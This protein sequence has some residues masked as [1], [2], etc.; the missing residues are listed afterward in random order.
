MERRASITSLSSAVTAKVSASS[1]GTK[2][3]PL[4][5]LERLVYRFSLLLKEDSTDGKRLQRV[6]KIRESSCFAKVNL[7]KLLAFLI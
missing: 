3:S 6:R 5:D 2:L 7:K 1:V 4:I